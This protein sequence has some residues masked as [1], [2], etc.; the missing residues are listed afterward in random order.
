MPIEQN[1]GSGH[2]QEQKSVRK[3]RSVSEMAQYRMFWPRDLQ[4]ITP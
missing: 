3:G 1:G 2:F 4:E